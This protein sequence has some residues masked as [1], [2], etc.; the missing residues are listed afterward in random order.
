[1]DWL[2]VGKFGI[3]EL[4]GKSLVH[5]GSDSTEMIRKIAR[6]VL[7][8]TAVTSFDRFHSSK[9]FQRDFRKL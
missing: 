9:L 7:R 1:M 8:C 2:E 6:G 5:V 3:L 4:F